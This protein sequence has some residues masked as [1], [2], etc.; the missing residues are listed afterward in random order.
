LTKHLFFF[1]EHFKVTSAD[2]VSTTVKEGAICVAS[3][4]TKTE[5]WRVR[6]EKLCKDQ[7]VSEC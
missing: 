7:L 6:V 4:Q 3:N 2:T 1:R 5:F